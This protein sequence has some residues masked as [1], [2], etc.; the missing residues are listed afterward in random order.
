MV[1]EK[2]MVRSGRDHMPVHVLDMD[3][4]IPFNPER[5]NACM[6]QLF[7]THRL[8]RVPP[9]LHHLHGRDLTR[10]HSDQHGQ[11]RVS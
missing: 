7:T 3:N 10:S 4:A 1:T 11:K 6:I 2:P 5:T 8:Y 9:K